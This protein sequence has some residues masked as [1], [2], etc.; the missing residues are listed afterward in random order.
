MS[1]DSETDKGWEPLVAIARAA[2]TRGLKGEIVADLLTDFPDRFADIASLFAVSPEGDRKAVRLESYWFQGNRII[3]KLV[4][5]DTVEAAETL[6]GYEFAVPESD[7]V[8]L[9]ADEFYEWELE[10]CMVQTSA[11]EAVGIVK[12]IMRTGSVDLVVVARDGKQEALV[13]M[14]SSMIVAVDKER[15]T[16][17]IDPPEGLLEL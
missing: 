17:T 14:V 16:I 9:A 12:G 6:R 4:D 7:R 3:L 10:G 8:E 13:P 1:V 2:K 11:G 15:R 5:Y